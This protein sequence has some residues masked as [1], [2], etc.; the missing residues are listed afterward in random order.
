M[1]FCASFEVARSR[2]GISVGA[3]KYELGNMGRRVTIS[4]RAIG[5]DAVGEEMQVTFEKRPMLD[6]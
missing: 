6:D 2:S 3:T 1:A 4:V 5:P